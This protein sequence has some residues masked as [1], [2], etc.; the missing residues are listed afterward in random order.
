MAM[1]PHNVHREE[2]SVELDSDSDFPFNFV[3]RNDAFG[4]FNKVIVFYST[5][6]SKSQLDLI[7]FAASASFTGYFF[8]LKPSNDSAGV[9]P[10]S[11]SR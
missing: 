3:R 5:C 4:F 7:P 9:T 8:K 2:V 1:R 6:G 10:V 11:S